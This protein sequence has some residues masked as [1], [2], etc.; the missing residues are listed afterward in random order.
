MMNESV[1]LYMTKEVITLGPENTLGEAREILLQK[2]IHHLPILD[3]RRL[4]GMLTSWD[5][6]KLGKSAEEYQNIPIKEVMTTKLATMEPDQH[7]GA[8]AEVLSKHLFHAVPIVNAHHE[9]LG[10][11]T[12][13]DIVRYEHSKEYP[14]NLDKFVP[15]NM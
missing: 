8:V 5:L 4:V 11:V 2:H 13:T 6:F 15:E 1:Q 3:G 14:E 7:L 9:L 10:I 12:S